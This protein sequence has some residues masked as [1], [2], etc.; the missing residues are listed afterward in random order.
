MCKTFQESREFDGYFRDIVQESTCK[1]CIELE[2]GQG[3]LVLSQ[4]FKFTSLKDGVLQ[5]I[6]SVD[7]GTG[8]LLSENKYIR[9]TELSLYDLRSLHNYVVNL[10]NYRVVS[11]K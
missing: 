8:I 1:T 4:P 6:H 11:N 3:E 5:H 7:C 10:K 9:Y 2:N